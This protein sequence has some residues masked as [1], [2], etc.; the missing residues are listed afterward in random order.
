MVI[1]SLRQWCDGKE[2]SRTLVV[3]PYFV[4]PRKLILEVHLVHGFIINMQP[5]IPTTTFCIR[6]KHVDCIVPTACALAVL[7]VERIF[8]ENMRVMG[9]STESACSPALPSS[10]SGEDYVQEAHISTMHYGIM[11]S[12]VVAK[13]EYDYNNRKTCCGGPRRTSIGGK[14]G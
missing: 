9:D 1:I 5:N 4:I 14:R 7:A 6:V 2:H 12:V 3:S 13:K 8:E 10:Q 11:V